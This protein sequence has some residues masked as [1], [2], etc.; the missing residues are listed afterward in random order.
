[1]PE[2]KETSLTDAVYEA[3]RSAAARRLHA[4]RSAYNILEHL[5][6]DPSEDRFGGSDARNTATRMINALEEMCMTT[7]KKTPPPRLAVFDVEDLGH[8]ESMVVVRR[9][10]FASV[11]EHHVLPWMGFVDVAY[12]PDQKVAGLS[13]MPRIVE[14]FS[15][16]LNMQERLGAQIANYL[17]TE[18]R[19]FGVG[20]RISARHTCMELRGIRAIGASTVT[21]TLRGVFKDPSVRSEFLS[22]AGE[23]A[24]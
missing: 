5:G 8:V 16:Q 1:M 20:V 6:V 22:N 7:F 13:K 9:I 3:T 10:P 18:L 21:T 19:C 4:V 2:E 15:R 14:Y 23:L 11:C 12:L 17:H 24:T